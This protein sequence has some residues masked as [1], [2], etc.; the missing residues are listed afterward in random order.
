MVGEFLDEEKKGIVPRAFDYIFEKI[1]FFQKKD[2]K[3]KFSVE[4]SFIQ[5][6]LELIG[7]LFEP[8]NEVKIR[9]DPEKGVYLEGVKWIKVES[10][11]ECAEAFINGEKNRKTAETK[12]NA[13]SSRSHALLIA[14][15]KKKFNDKESNSH[16]MTESYLYLVDLAGSERVTK[17]N[18]KEDRLKE[19]KKINYSLLVLGNCIQSLIDPKNSHISYRDSKLTRILQESLGGNAKTSLIVTISPSSYNT[20]ETVSSLN[21]GARAMKVK[22]KPIINQT[23]DYQAQLI[24]LQEDYDKLNDDYSKLKIEYDIVCEENEKLKNNDNLI[25]VKKNNI[26]EQ[27]RNTDNLIGSI[28]SLN[29]E[30]NNK[31][32]IEQ[33]KIIDEL[34]SINLNL[35]NEM[36]NLQNYYSE[37]IQKKENEYNILMKKAEKENYYMEEVIEELKNNNYNLQNQKNKLEEELKEIIEEK[38]ELLNS[39]HD[40]YQK[41]ESMNFEIEMLKK[42]KLDFEKVIEQLRQEKEMKKK[43]LKS[44]SI[45]TPLLVEDDIKNNLNKIGIPITII[46]KN[47]VNSILKNLLKQYNKYVFDKNIFEQYKKENQDYKHVLQD[48]NEL[49]LKNLKL[50]NEI[51]N[52][53]NKINEL[54]KKNKELENNTLN[55]INDLKSK[56]EMNLQNSLNQIQELTNKNKEFENCENQLNNLF[57]NNLGKLSK[58]QKEINELNSFLINENDSQIDNNLDA[59]NNQISKNEKLLKDLKN[60]PLND[61]NIKNEIDNKISEINNCF[62]SIFNSH[63]ELSKKLYKQIK[64]KNKSNED[65][66][67]L[68]NDNNI[69]KKFLLKLNLIEKNGQYKNN[70]SKALSN[71]NKITYSEILEIALLVFGNINS[72]NNNVLFNKYNSV[73]NYNDNTNDKLNQNIKNNY[74]YYKNQQEEKKYA[75]KSNDKTNYSIKNKKKFNIPQ[76]N[77]PNIETH[78]NNNFEKYDSFTTNENIDDLINEKDKELEALQAELKRIEEKQAKSKYKKKNN[79]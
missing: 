9:E 33:Q 51:S 20:E 49:K 18:A 4:I 62:Y 38:E 40:I 46:A 12:M 39:L 64:D 73:Y 45:Q 11:K 54:E 29:N 76:R 75:S 19:A 26:M 6:Y 57:S 25:E 36:E 78:I 77:I 30:D 32:L 22:N 7:D 31:N 61:E 3:T 60:V 34:N 8:N 50:N 69:K 42:K 55:E 1:K 44:I 59:I 16:V 71:I 17:T 43:N 53:E 13:T 27:L 63:L 79:E 15:I 24:K 14:K 37:E 56:Y 10:T 2:E 48:Y 72:N 21:F 47:D 5:I 67:N 66:I 23:V 28:T 65:N 58:L 68:K 70:I 35:K 52:K 41:N 74:V